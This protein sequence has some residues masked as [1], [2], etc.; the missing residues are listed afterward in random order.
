MDYEAPELE[1]L[2]VGVE[3]G[4]SSSTNFNDPDI[5]DDYGNDSDFWG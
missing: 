1:L 5:N 3:Q 4:F 2:L